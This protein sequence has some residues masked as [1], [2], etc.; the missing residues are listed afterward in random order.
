MRLIL[1][2]PF[3]LLACGPAAT[4]PDAGS[5]CRDNPK[6]PANLLE[7]PGF[8]CDGAEWA[9]V[10]GYGSFDVTTGGR[11]GRAGRITVGGLG[12]RAQYTKAFAPEPAGQRTFCV[13]AWV[14]GTAPFMRLRVLRDFGGGVQEDSFA[15]PITSTFTRV[16]PVNPLKITADNAPKIL[17]VFEVQTNRTDGQNGMSGQTLLIDD[18][19]VWET[20]SNCSESR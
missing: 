17:L 7:N 18:V 8:E 1:L 13:N 9:A 4:A 14:S 3:V 5:V 20:T 10:P 16:P 19:D 6:T 12:G 11:S 15:A 2:T